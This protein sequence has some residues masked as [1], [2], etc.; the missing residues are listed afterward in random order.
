MLDTCSRNAGRRL[1][2]L[3]AHVSHDAPPLLDDGPWMR[4]LP[5]CAQSLPQ[6]RAVLIVSAHWEHAPLSLSAPAAHTPLVY[7][8]A[9]F[10]PDTAR[11][12]TTPPTQARRPDTRRR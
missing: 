7:D 8:F 11:R 12:S 4:R 5:G 6:P 10:H 3:P 1:R 2:R 9:G